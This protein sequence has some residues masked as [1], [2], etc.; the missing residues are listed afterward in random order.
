VGLPAFGNLKESEGLRL[1]FKE[2]D[3]ADDIY[4]NLNEDIALPGVQKYYSYPV[5]SG[6]NIKSILELNNGDLFLGR[7]SVANGHIF[8]LSSPL[9]NS[10]NSLAEDAL[11]L[12][13]M[14]K[15][16]FYRSSGIPNYI[17]LGEKDFISINNYSNKSEEDLLAM[18]G[19]S[20]EMIPAQR[21]VQ[22]SLR[23]YF[24][25]LSPKPGHYLLK[26]GRENSE[27][28]GALGMNLGRGESDLNY[29]TRERL[30][31]ISDSLNFNL[32][33]STGANVVKELNDLEKG[34]ALFKWFLAASLCLLIIEIV[35]IKYW[36]S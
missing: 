1:S 4:E 9:N 22:G 17:V 7:S 16:A 31:V 29:Y 20:V 33:E 30:G 36:R 12:P 11:F 3:F 34:K 15:M 35:L 6:T 28:I 8:L 26:K 25:N 27:T 18:V 21:Q 32:L 19:E 2:T 23:I 10:W 13:L 24:D 5:Y 14:F